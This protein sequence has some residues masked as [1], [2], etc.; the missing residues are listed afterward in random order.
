MDDGEVR[1]SFVDLLGWLAMSYYNG[2]EIGSILRCER[3]GHED[4]DDTGYYGDRCKVDGI[5]GC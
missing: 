2:K 3:G 4:H 1:V 5:L